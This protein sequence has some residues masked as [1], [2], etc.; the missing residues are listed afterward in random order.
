[1]DIVHEQWKTCDQCPDYAVSNL[2]NVK[3][4]T[5]YKINRDYGGPSPRPNGRGYL[6]LGVKLNGKQTNFQ[7]HRL[8]MRAF[9][10]PS[11]LQVNHKNGDKHDNRLENLEYVTPA[12]N[13]QHSRDVLKTFQMGERHHNHKLTEADIP[14]IFL[15]AKSGVSKN[16]I[17]RMF[18]VT[19]ANICYILKRKG[20]RHVHIPPDL[21]PD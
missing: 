21:L 2:G 20:W 7:I 3:R 5:P 8:V 10:G 4:V 6:Y 14:D 13:Q 17:G 11:D 18:G 15:L 12:E 1:M 16:Q 19:G 9:V